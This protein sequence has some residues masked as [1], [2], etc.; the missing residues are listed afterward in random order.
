MPWIVSGLLVWTLAL[1]GLRAQGQAI[2]PFTR[3]FIVIFALVIGLAVGHVAGTAT[4]LRD[5]A[6]T[7]LFIKTGLD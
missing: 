7:E 6:R 2:L 4:W 1:A 5:A 3:G